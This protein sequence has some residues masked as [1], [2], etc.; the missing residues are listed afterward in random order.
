LADRIKN[1]P[2]ITWGT[3]HVPG[4]AALIAAIGEA[5]V[6]GIRSGTAMLKAATKAAQKFS[7]TS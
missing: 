7:A 3:D 2:T 4:E 5:E 6:Q 1:A